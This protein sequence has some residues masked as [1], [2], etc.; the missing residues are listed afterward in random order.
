MGMLEPESSLHS[1]DT[2]GPELSD[3]AVTSPS[4]LFVTS[5]YSEDTCSV[6]PDLNPNVESSLIVTLPE[7]ESFAL[8]FG[9]QIDEPKAWVEVG[10]PS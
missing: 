10:P 8:D 7:V 3:T 9:Y 6:T 2:T 4:L 5:W 1:H